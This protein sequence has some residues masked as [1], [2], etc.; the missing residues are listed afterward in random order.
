[1][2]GW[3]GGFGHSIRSGWVGPEGGGSPS[4]LYSASGWVILEGRISPPDMITPLGS[5]KNGDILPKWGEFE[6]SYRASGSGWPFGGHSKLDCL[7]SSA[8]CAYSVWLSQWVGS[9]WPDGSGSPIST[10]W[11]GT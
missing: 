8:D 10:S 2:L 3:A 7:G 5:Y 1:M 4:G 11:V 9:D 6:L